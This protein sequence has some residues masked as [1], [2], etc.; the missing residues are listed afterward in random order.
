MSRG[1]RQ[2]RPVPSL[3]CATIGVTLNPDKAVGNGTA[4]PT[5]LV[6]ALSRLR[7]ASTKSGVALMLPGVPGALAF[8]VVLQALAI[9]YM[10]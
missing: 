7:A 8:G 3:F 4:L 1:F 9:L 10:L 6:P 5:P 2:V